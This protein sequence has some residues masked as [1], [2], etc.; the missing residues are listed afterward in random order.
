M[1]EELVYLKS[2][3]NIGYD[4]C[5]W[6]LGEGILSGGK[7]KR[8]LESKRPSFD[9][10]GTYWTNG[11]ITRLSRLSGHKDWKWEKRMPVLISMEPWVPE[12]FLNIGYDRHMFVELLNGGNWLERAVSII[13]PNLSFN[14]KLY[15]PV[16][17]MLY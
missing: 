11:R 1:H 13:L 16:W 8:R 10:I 17:V 2:L 6:V 12:D 14:S 3:L 15:R 9:I 7:S 5:V 4:L